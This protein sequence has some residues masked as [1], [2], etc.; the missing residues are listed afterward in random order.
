[1][2]SAQEDAKPPAPAEGKATR[3]RETVVTA[4]RTEEDAFNVPYSTLTYDAEDIQLRR[5][6]RTVPEVFHEEPSILVQKTARGQASPYLRGFTGFRNLFLIDGI[7]LNNSVFRDGPNQYW[8]TVDPFLVSRLEVVKGPSSVLYGSDAIGGTVNAIT[9]R[10]EHFP[11]GFNWSRRVHYRFGSA[12]R[13]HVGRMEVEGNYGRTLGFLF[14]TTLSDFND[15]EAGHGVGEMDN[16][17][18]DERNF[19]ARLDY[20]L[21]P[22]TRLTLAHQRYRQDD[23]WRAHKTLYG[24]SWHGTDVG[25]E[26]ERSLDQGRELTYLQYEATHLD[27]FVDAVRLSASWHE[28]KEDQF[29]I[30]GNGSF[31][32]QGVKVGTLGLG[33]QLTS[34]SPLG[35]LTY[36]AEFY[37][38]NVDSYARQW[39]PTGAFKGESIQGPVADNA[40]Y[41]LLGVYVQD[42]FALTDRLEAILG[43][44]YTYAAADADEVEDPMSGDEIEVGDRWDEL[45]GSA[46]LLYHATESLNFFGGVS[47]G[48]RAPNLSDLTRLDSAR[49]GEIETP[50]PGLDAER[51]VSAEI[52]TKVDSERFTGQVAYYYT[53]IRDMIV[54]YPTGR[55]IDGE[56]EVQKANVGD[57]YVHGIELNGEY[58]FTDEWAV[59]GGLAWQRGEADTYATSAREKT[60]EPISRML[61]FSAVAGLRWKERNGRFW[62]EALGRMADE[63]HRLSPSDERDTQR[64]PPGGTPGYG[65]VDLR[66]GCRLATDMNVTVALENLFDAAYRIH[67]SG[68]NEPGRNL[69]V[70][71]DWRF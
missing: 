10:R 55:T 47:Q 31:D 21:D 3:Q 35:L 17:G 16:T 28:Q 70:A 61:P 29:R 52:G 68:Q 39:T 23:A 64:I 4:T 48:F 42:E 18:Y 41:D 24:V 40:T 33:A 49:S 26:R 19:D 65:V 25:D 30:K 34:D 8:G 6:A 45:T 22:N 11:D 58:R 46:R 67:G 36:G 56:A 60:R 38:D 32:E 1:M 12:D 5:L 43:A 62:F 71:V 7:R 50:S 69:V 15:L 57:G 54:R 9:R 51:T 13:S 20:W 2:A 53:W 14:G 37:R 59:F 27:S 66:A 44:R 63:Q